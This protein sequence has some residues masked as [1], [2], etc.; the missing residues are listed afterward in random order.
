MSTSTGEH[1][2]GLKK[3]LDFTRL[4]AIVIL[5]L[6]YYYY[7][8]AAFEQWK[9]TA[10]MGNRFLVNLAR[11]GLYKSLY[12]SKLIAL[13]LLT[14]SLLGTRGKKSEKISPQTIL[15]YIITGL[16]TYS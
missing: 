13:V 6:H 1:E 7:C 11:T 4:G 2:M 3:I 5:L 10:E 14:I 15:L 12:I 9:L 8:Y 16:L